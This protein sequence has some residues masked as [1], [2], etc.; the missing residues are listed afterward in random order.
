[1]DGGKK[2]ISEVK[3]KI[4]TKQLKVFQPVFKNSILIP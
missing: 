3:I 2:R 1:M 4:Y